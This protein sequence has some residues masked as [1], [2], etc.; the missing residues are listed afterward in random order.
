MDL[1]SKKQL[2]IMLSM[3]DLLNKTVNPNWKEAGN[4]WSLAVLLEA[5]EAID[6]TGWKWWKEQVPNIPQL[7]LE[8]VDIWHFIIS[9]IM[10]DNSVTLEEMKYSERAAISD[11]MLEV[12]SE[13]M[14]SLKMTWSELYKIYI[15]KHS[16]NM[17]RQEHGYKDGSY[18]KDWSSYK[19]VNTTTTNSGVC[20]DNDHL[21]TEDK[22]ILTNT[23][24]A[25]RYLA[26]LADLIIEVVDEVYKDLEHDIM[27]GIDEDIDDIIDVVNKELLTRYTV[28]K[29][30]KMASE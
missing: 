19:L 21:G 25:L 16:L 2:V 17:F 10:S 18:I 8:I 27:L 20:E 15:G 29:N 30:M 7:K 5:S 1:P 24:A 28:I 3:Q 26:Y 11:S 23:R 9:E 4:D 22:E 6:H 13:V 12:F 14:F